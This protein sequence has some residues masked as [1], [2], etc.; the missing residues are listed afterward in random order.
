MYYATSTISCDVLR[1]YIILVVRECD[2][3]PTST[4][5][6]N[7]LARCC[8]HPMHHS[9]LATADIRLDRS[10]RVSYCCHHLDSILH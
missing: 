7:A 1:F 10:L 2:A 3:Y 6:T 4:S 9:L 5:T 8:H